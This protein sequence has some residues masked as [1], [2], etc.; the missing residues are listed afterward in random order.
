MCVCFML[1][2][3]S[4]V[5]CFKNYTLKTGQQLHR[6]GE[7]NAS[8]HTICLSE[9]ASRSSESNLEVG[10]GIWSLGVR[11]ASLSLAPPVK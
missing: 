2:R 3:G 1:V 11:N 10:A 7:N 8:G 9:G 6:P 5:K 4:G